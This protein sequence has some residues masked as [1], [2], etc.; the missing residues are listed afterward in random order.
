LKAPDKLRS[1]NSDE[2]GDPGNSQKEL[3]HRAMEAG[4]VQMSAIVLHNIGNAI[5]PIKVHLESMRDKTFLK[6]ARY[7]EKCHEDLQAHVDSLQH[8]VKEDPRGKEVFVYLGSLIAALKKEEE[9]RTQVLQKMDEAVSYISEILTLQQGYAASSQEAKGKVDLNGLVEDAIR[10]QAA[11][12]EKRK[13]AVRKELRPNLPKLLI[14]KNRLIQVI[15]N[16]I[17]NSYE[18]IE[19]LEDPGKPGEI[20][21]RS[22][23]KDGQ[24]V[25][26]IADAGVGIEPTDLER[27]GAFGQSTKGSSGFGLY[28]CKMFLEAQN[29]FMRIQSEGR[30]KGTTVSIGLPAAPQAPP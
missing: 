8:Y 27:I 22:L 16:L 14:E 9:R 3:V 12:L 23:E 19:E 26:E 2:A 1:W 17:K 15:V 30:G 25:L 20:L 11:A 7:L 4:R 6:I 28:Y 13:I 10:M 29:G 18:A 5:T 21:F 24:V